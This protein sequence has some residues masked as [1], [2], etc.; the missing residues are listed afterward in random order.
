MD[1]TL[2]QANLVEILQTIQSTSELE[3]PPLNGKTK[4]LED[5]PEFDSKIWPVAIGM[6]S[7]KLGIYIPP[8]V[9]IFRQEDSA[10]ALTIDEIVAKV[11]TIAEGQATEAHKKANKQ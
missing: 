8:D 7:M 9:N 6:L 3:C 1:S 2:I 10:T 4:P 5:L 11:I